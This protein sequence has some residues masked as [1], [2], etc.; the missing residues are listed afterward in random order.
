VRPAVA[1]SPRKHARVGAPSYAAPGSSRSRFITIECGAHRRAVADVHVVDLQH[2]VLER[3]RL[4][5]R[6]HRD[7][8]AE[9]QHVGVDHVGEAGPEQPST[10]ASIRVPSSAESGAAAHM[11]QAT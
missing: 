3:V 9:M 8:V 4:E 2:A 5:Q 10:G 7:V 6:L 11:L 1:P